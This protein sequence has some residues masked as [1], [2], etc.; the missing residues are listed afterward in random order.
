MN[1]TNMTVQH[2]PRPLIAPPSTPFGKVLLAIFV[3]A[4]C[5][6]LWGLYL[7]L[8]QGH[9]PAGYGS[10]V[11]WG[12]WIAL[13]FHGVGIAGGVF[14]LG[15]G[16][17]LL[18]LP[19]FSSK[20]ALRMTIVLSFAAIIPAF[21]G[22]WF[23]L[24]HMDRAAAIF[25]RPR[26]TSMM[27]FNA[28]MYNAYMAIAAICFLLSFKRQS[29][30]LKPLLCVALISTA[31]FPSQSGAF[32]A[33]V[34]AKPY[35][36]S[37]LLPVLFLTS[38]VTAGAATLLLAR[39][40][41]GDEADATPGQ[42]DAAVRLLRAITIGGV[43]AYF[44]MEFAEF[45]IAFWNPSSHSEALEIVLSGPFWWVFWIVHL[46]LGGVLALAFLLSR[47]RRLW[48]AGALLVAIC[49]VS[50]R[51]NVL[52]P[53]QLVAQLPGLDDAFWHPRLQYVYYATAMEYAVGILLVA[54]AMAVFYAGN[55]L[56]RMLTA[57]AHPGE[58][59]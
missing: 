47:S 15:A 3:V 32:F 17:Y 20:F 44:L 5:V 59:S 41:I 29:E 33:V 38:A 52:V 12:L 9:L 19:G 51:L 48:L 28:W 53:G 21:M 45:S 8:T 42:A 49:F 4:A 43:T 54:M 50:A 14:L 40:V 26:F 25:L 46:M 36:H 2:R 56:N 34:D 27:A 39:A 18:G 55:T 31:L 37:A 57:R 24:G 6:G 7:R 11:P 35:W 13:Y 30:W 1:A 10:Y 23:D 22:V 58:S 16:G